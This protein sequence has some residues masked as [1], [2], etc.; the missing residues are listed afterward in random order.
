VHWHDRANI[1]SEVLAE[2][3]L[4]RNHELTLTV[5]VTN[6]QSPSALT[7]KLSAY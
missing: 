6:S 3:T 5:T 1:P 4:D 7:A 2:H